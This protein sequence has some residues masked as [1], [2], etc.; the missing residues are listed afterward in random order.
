M[1]KE[2]EEHAIDIFGRE[3]YKK[4]VE[5][6][7]SIFDY[8]VSSAGSV[9]YARIS[10][11]RCERKFRLWRK[12]IDGYDRTTEKWVEI[13]KDCVRETDII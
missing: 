1:T 12:C 11:E 5:R 8:M 9:S 2:D 4:M 6:G 3:E 13:C 7:G 10:C